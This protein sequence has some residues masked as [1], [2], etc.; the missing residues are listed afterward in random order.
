A[1]GVMTSVRDQSSRSA[2]NGAATR[3]SQAGLC[4]RQCGFPACEH[5]RKGGAQLCGALGSGLFRRA[6]IE[7]RLWIIF[8]RELDE[9]GGLFA[10]EFGGEREA[11]IDPRGH[12]AAGDAV[13]VANHALRYRLGSQRCQHVAPCP[14]AGGLV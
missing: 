8:E 1:A 10:S 5:F 7:R 4:L 14:M 3:W 13:A 6:T 9:L 2:D 12:A 11:K